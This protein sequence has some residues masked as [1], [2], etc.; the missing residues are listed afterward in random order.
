MTIVLFCHLN[1]F[2]VNITESW[3]EENCHYTLS[4]SLDMVVRFVI[5]LTISNFA[6]NVSPNSKFVSS[7]KTIC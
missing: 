4:L 2:N 5:K 6:E 3:F 7:L 1:F